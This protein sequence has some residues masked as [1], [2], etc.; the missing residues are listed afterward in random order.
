MTRIV[1]TQIV[2]AIDE[3]FPWAK[4][5]QKGNQ[6]EGRD[7]ARSVG[8]WRLPGIVEMLGQIP[9]E[10][11]IL[12]SE[13]ETEFLFASVALRH[14]VDVLAL[15]HREVINWPMIGNRDCVN[16]VREALLKCPDEGPSASAAGLTFIADEI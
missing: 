10:L 14:E 1:P 12:E 4:D 13:Q 9:D 8:V 5:W 11:L 7:Q 6:V 16:I 2:R 3:F 15:G